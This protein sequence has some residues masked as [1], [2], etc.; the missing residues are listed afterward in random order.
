MKG[1][2]KAITNIKPM[3]GGVTIAQLQTG[4][5]AYGT[6][7]ATD[8]M[9]FSHFYR[10]DNTKVELGKMCKAYLG[11][12]IL[13]NDAEPIVEPPPVDPPIDPVPL[14][15]DGIWEIDGKKM[16]YRFVKYV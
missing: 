14:E 4:D 1:T 8:L 5:Y 9:N 12:L 2:A 16:L 11:N 3:D 6:Q 7:G 13:S 15:P 10:K